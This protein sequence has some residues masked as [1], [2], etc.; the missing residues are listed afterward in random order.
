[1]AAGQLKYALANIGPTT[2]VAT[3][4]DSNLTLLHEMLSSN[5]L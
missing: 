5:N 2:P 4:L 1:M 3:A